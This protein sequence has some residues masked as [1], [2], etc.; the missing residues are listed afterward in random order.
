MRVDRNK[1]CYT[2]CV[3]GLGPRTKKISPFNK[4][5]KNSGCTFGEILLEL[6]FFL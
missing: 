3:A 1:N 6:I 5:V 2:G 4:Q